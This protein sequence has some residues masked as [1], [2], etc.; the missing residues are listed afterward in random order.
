M[1]SPGTPPL[2]IPYGV[3]P[4]I[5]IIAH[6][7]RARIEDHACVSIG[8]GLRQLPCHLL[9]SLAVDVS[10]LPIDLVLANPPTVLAAVDAALSLFPPLPGHFPSDRLSN[11]LSI[12]CQSRKDTVVVP[13]LPIHARA[14]SSGDSATVCREICQEEA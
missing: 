2:R 4:P 8:H 13:L 3:E 1:S 12:S 5:E 9:T 14:C 11:R 7:Q 10:T 6:S